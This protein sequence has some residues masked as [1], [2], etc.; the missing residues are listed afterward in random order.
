MIRRLITGSLITL[1]ATV[2]GA[3]LN[4]TDISQ[5][6]VYIGTYTG[7]KSKGIYLARLDTRTGALSAPELAA[8]TA[9]P[10]FLAVHPNRRFLYA[11]N[12]VWNP[13]GKPSPTVTAFGIAAAS[14]KLPKLNEQ[15][16]GGAGPCHVVVDQAGKNVVVANYGGGSLATFPVGADGRLGAATAFIQHHGASVNPQ[17]QAAPHAHGIAIDPA[18]QFVFCADLGLDKVMSYRFDP[19]HGTLTPNDPPAVALQ[20]GAGPRHFVFHLTG[21]FGYVIN[22]IASTITAFSYNATHGALVELQTVSTLPGDFKGMSSTAEIT[23][24]PNGKFLYGSNRGHDSIAVFAIDNQTGKLTLV[25]FQ[26]TQGKSPRNF[27]IDPTGQLLVVANQDSDNIVV[28][29][30]DPETGQLHPTESVVTVGA[31]ACVVFVPPGLPTLAT[32]R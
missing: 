27:A 7:A 13:T 32:G 23:V 17:R 29:R 28:F 12:E 11:V 3:S 14:G 26:P 4:P 15:P 6:L 18:N 8:E 2:H 19:A 24:H 30:I 31:P 16:T 20:P 21:R 25:E 9:N 22:E 1:S 10:S 5:T